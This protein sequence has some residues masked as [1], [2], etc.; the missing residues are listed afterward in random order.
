MLSGPEIARIV[1]QFDDEYIYDNDPDDPQNCHHEA[2]RA[3][4]QTFQ[5][6]VKS[7][8]NVVRTMGNPFQD[9]F[10]ELIKLDTRDCVNSGV[11]ETL[12]SF[13]ETG[14]QQYKDYKKAVIAEGSKC[15]DD[16]IKKNNLPLFKKP[17]PKQTSKQGKKISALQSNVALFAQLYV[18]MQ[19]RDSDLK[20]F[21]AHEVHSFPPSL[22]DFGVLRLPTA[23]SDLLKCFP[24]Y[25][26]QSNP[27]THFDCRIL[28]GAVIVHSLQ[29]AGAVT[30]EDYADKI[31]IPHIQ[32]HL[33]QSQR[34]DI[35][36]DAYIPDSLKES[37]REKRGAG[38][39]RKVS[40]QAKIP[41]NWMAFLR[42][43][44][45]KLE[46]FQ[47][48][49][50]KIS[51]FAF[52]SEKSVCITSGKLCFKLLVVAMYCTCKA[53]CKCKMQYI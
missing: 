32:H 19:N 40:S 15:I 7:L 6:Q 4:Q 44:T 39:R 41:S 31:F 2:G 22:S 51:L 10:P 34:V 3:S 16:T 35:V 52:P 43:S 42:D 37:T 8:T 17:I 27:P 12:R 13:E 50:Q 45:N 47:F 53:N 30:F 20:E 25:A 48:L 14:K 28:D 33:Q 36:W 26:E 23:K 11:S 5:R 24:S 21:F 1:K 29:P 49:S 46:L 9:D 18:A 38:V